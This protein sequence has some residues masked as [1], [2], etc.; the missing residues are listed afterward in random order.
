MLEPHRKLTG[1][2]ITHPTDPR[3]RGLAAA[4]LA[5]DIP[6]WE[7]DIRAV[8]PGTDPLQVSDWERRRRLKE[9]EGSP[10]AAIAPLP[11]KDGKDHGG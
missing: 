8:E 4:I 2:A 5:S 9:R 1:M 10:S 3:I 11:T 7:F 6:C